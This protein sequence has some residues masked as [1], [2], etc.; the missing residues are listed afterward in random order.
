MPAD[1]SLNA[2]AWAQTS[3]EHDMV[4]REIYRVAREKLL[5]ALHD[6]HW[7]ALPRDARNP[8]GTKGLK[9]AVILD[10][11]ETVLDNSVYQARLIRDRHEY[12]DASFAAWVKEEAGT[13]IPGALAF[14]RFAARHGVQVI[15]LTNRDKSLDQATL[16][17]LR[18]QGFPVHGKYA[19]LGLGTYVKGC[20]QIGSQK[21]CRRELV[22]RHYRVLMEFGDQL[23]DFLTVLSN[24]P[25]GRRDAVKPYVGWFG[26]RWFMLPNPEYGSWLPALFHNVWAQPQ[27]QRRREILKHLHYK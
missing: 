24:T 20:E 27:E 21:S 7:N 19:F 1:D 10:V 25:K 4:T 11:D 2:T 6:P 16:D 17:N 12:N 18:K 3:V 5:K 13:P 15:Y 22:G 9:P 23:G 8:H 14:T 26:S